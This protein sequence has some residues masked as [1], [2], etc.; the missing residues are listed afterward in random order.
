MCKKKVDFLSL[1]M[2]YYN[3]FYLPNYVITP[4]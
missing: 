3:Y 1:E 4:M 2:T